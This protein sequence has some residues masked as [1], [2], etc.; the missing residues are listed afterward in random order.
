MISIL[1]CCTRS[2]SSA[3]AAPWN[4]SRNN[5]TAIPVVVRCS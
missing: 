5:A 4:A 1:P 3:S 2:T